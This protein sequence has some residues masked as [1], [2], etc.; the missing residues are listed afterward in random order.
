MPVLSSQKPKRARLVGKK[1]L[2]QL[3]PYLIQRPQKNLQPLSQGYQWEPR[4]TLTRLKWKNPLL[5]AWVVLQK[6]EWGRKAFFLPGVRITSSVQSFSCI[7]LFVIPWISACQASLSTTDSRSSLNL[8]SIWVELMMPSNHLILC[9][10]FLL[11]SV[12]PR[13]RIHSNKSVPLTRWPKY[14][15]CSFSISPSTG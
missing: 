6:T 8:M 13:I 12:F 5:P 9:H 1:I 2:R 4:Q 11:P 15:S 3:L 14:W 7:Q 10:P